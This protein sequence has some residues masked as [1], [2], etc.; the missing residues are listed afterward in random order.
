MSE[1]APGS[2][3]LDEPGTDGSG[4]SAEL[5]RCPLTQV[6]SAEVTRVP[7]EAGPIAIFNLEGEL[8]AVQDTCS[9]EDASLADGFLEG[10]VIECPLHGGQFDLRSGAA[11]CLPAQ[12]PLRR[13]ATRTDGEFV[14]VS[15]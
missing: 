2:T 9:H 1:Q 12:H 6:R 10:H 5:A 13:F 3:E 15:T 11:V 14:Y 4:R 8:L 7:S